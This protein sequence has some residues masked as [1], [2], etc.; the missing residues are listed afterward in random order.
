MKRK[1][2]MP[3]YTFKCDECSEMTIKNISVSEYIRFKKETNKCPACKAGVLFQKLSPV[4]NTV[5]RKKEDLMPE[6]Q[7]G[8]REIIKKLE[9]GDENTI[10]DIFGDSKN[11]LK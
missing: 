2:L 7:A 5:E 9:Q 11:K 3:R 4:R 1:N 10:V 8:A 6:I